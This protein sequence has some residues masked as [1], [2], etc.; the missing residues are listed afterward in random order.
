MNPTSYSPTCWGLHPALFHN[1]N[2][3]CARRATPQS[4]GDSIPHYF[5][6]LTGYVPEEVGKRD[7][8]VSKKN[9]FKALYSTQF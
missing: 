5:I 7:F 6:I 1:F 3:L 4:V 2:G 8:Y 9:P